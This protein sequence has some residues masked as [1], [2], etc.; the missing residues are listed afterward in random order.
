[1]KLIPVP[2]GGSS[3][4]TNRYTVWIDNI[5]MDTRFVFESIIIVNM[6]FMLTPICLAMPRSGMSRNVGIMLRLFLDSRQ[7]FLWC[8]HFLIVTTTA[9]IT[10]NSSSSTTTTT[11][12]C[13]VTIRLASVAIIKITKHFLVS[14]FCFLSPFIVQLVCLIL[15]LVFPFFIPSLSQRTTTPILVIRYTVPTRQ[16]RSE[17][18]HSSQQPKDGRHDCQYTTSTHTTRCGGKL[19]DG[20]TRRGV[21]KEP[22]GTD[23]AA[24]DNEC[25]TVQD[26]HQQQSV[27]DIFVSVW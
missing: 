5:I 10:T 13:L 25:G 4:T 9:I 19:R 15:F 23:R 22:V 20:Y 11:T 21:I 26:R 18:D 7:P 24:Q 12:I 8:R 2:L 1:M 16:G 6:L 27:S 3:I 17:T 14:S